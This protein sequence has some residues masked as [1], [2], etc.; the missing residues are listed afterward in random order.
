MRVVRH[1]F[2]RSR[3]GGAAEVLRVIAVVDNWQEHFSACGVTA[4]DI[5]SLAERID[6]EVLLAERRSF[7]PADHT[8]ARGKRRRSPFA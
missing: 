6:G 5:A 4:A 1:E 7:S 3:C 2:E 8:A